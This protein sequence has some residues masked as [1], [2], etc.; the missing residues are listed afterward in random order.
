[1]ANLKSSIKRVK[2]SNK[3]TAINK[4]QRSKLRTAL[5]K[6]RVAVD[7]DAEDAEDLAKA[8][9]KAL[10]RAASKGLISKNKAARHKS[11]LALALNKNEA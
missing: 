5:K 3:E 10:D 11:Q 7:E 1:M 4:A 6:A 2:T 9:Y 8:A